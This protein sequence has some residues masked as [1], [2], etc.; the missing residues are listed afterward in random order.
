MS[1]ITKW[2]NNEDSDA[3]DFYWKCQAIAEIIR[4]ATPLTIILSSLITVAVIANAITNSPVL[5]TLLGGG[6]SGGLGLAQGANSKGKEERIKLSD[7]STQTSSNTLPIETSNDAR[8][9]ESK[10]EPDNVISMQRGVY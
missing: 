8:K 10:P 2:K 5:A 1:D 7:Q 6:V 3:D 4:A 9:E